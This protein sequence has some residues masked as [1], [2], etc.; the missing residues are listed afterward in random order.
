MT[1]TANGSRRIL[2]YARFV[3]NDSDRGS[4]AEIQRQVPGLAFTDAQLLHEFRNKSRRLLYAP[5]IQYCEAL[6]DRI[7][8]ARAERAIP[9][10]SDANGY[11]RLP[12][13][14][15]AAYATPTTE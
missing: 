8:R 11:D 14:A 4:I 7:A 15:Q 13:S 12:T 2:E 6:E 3:L 10:R 9:L 1:S 5:E